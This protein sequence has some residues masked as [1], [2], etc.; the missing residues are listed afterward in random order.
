MFCRLPTFGKASLIRG[1]GSPSYPLS[2]STQ[3]SCKLQ[4]F[5]ISG[6]S[7][8]SAPITPSQISPANS[9]SQTSY[10]ETPPNTFNSSESFNLSKTSSETHLSKA[11]NNSNLQ[12]THNKT[13]SLTCLSKTTSQIDLNKT[14]LQ[15]N[16]SKSS[17]QS[18][19]SKTFKSNIN[20]TPLQANVNRTSSQTNIGK[21]PNQ[22]LNKNLS[23]SIAKSPYQTTLNKSATFIKNIPT[24]PDFNQ[25]S[26]PS[27]PFRKPYASLT[28]RTGSATKISAQPKYG[29]I[30]KSFP[31]LLH[32]IS[33]HYNIGILPGMHAKLTKEKEDS[34][35]TSEKVKKITCC[36]LK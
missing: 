36:M 4:S 26:S 7:I 29:I 17:S 13:A 12:S 31:S 22:T 33:R 1:F 18:N 6:Y 3:S 9:L 20:K 21:A 16:I 19:I 28:M 30:L 27:T 5:N 34:L 8:A 15:T 23:Q 11:H 2:P 25:S 10:Y 14:P 35:K 24:K 32:T